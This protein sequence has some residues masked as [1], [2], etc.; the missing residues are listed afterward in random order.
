MRI[1]SITLLGLVLVVAP[2][3]SRAGDPVTLTRDGWTVT[4]DEA[5]AT[6]SIAH[7]RLGPL[8]ENARLGTEDDV[9]TPSWTSWSVAAGP[10]GELT[11][12]TG[13]SSTTW[14][15]APGPDTLIISST[16]TRAVLAGEAP[17]G[18]DRVVAR[19][20]DPSGVPVQW[21]GTNEVA[22]GYGGSETR[23]PSYLPTRNSDV[24]Y[25]GL[26]PVANG[27]F[28]A[29][30][31]RRSDTAVSFS[32][33]TRLKSHTGDP[34][35]IDLSIPVPGATVVRLV[36]DYYTT[37]LGVPFYERFDD[38]RFPRPPTI[39]CSWTSYYAEV[40]EEDMVKNA[41]WIAEHLLPWGFQ[42]VQ[43]DDGYD[44]GPHGEHYW[45]ERWDEKKFPHGPAWLAGYIKSKGLR[46]GLWLVPNAYAG[47]VETHPDWYLRD[48][49]GKLILDYNTPALDQTNPDVL[50]F[51]GQEFTTLR[52]WG[53]EYY[54]FDGEHALPLYVPA[55]DRSKLY[56]P[57]ADPIV[58]YRHRLSVIRDTVGPDT[59]I[60]GCPAGTPL[61]GIGY[62]DSYFDGHDVYNSWPGMFALFSSINANA[63]LNHMV[64]YLMPGEGIDVGPPMS[65][66]EAEKR[67]PPSF[68]RTARTRED[69]LTGF[70]T[71]LPE[72]R[73]LVTWLALTGVAYPVASVMP[74]LP[75][76]RVAL[77]QATLPP[78]PAL[79]IDLFSRGTDMQ[80]DRFKHV[81][82]D[83]YIHHYPEVLDLKV[84]GASGTYD[85][86]GI[87][88]WRAKPLHRRL[89]FHRTLGLEP[90][91]AVVAFDFWNQKPL[92]VFE[93]GLELD[94]EPHDTRVVL[95]HPLADR[96]QVIGTSRHITG[97]HSLLSLEWVAASRRL[98]GS[99][100]TVPGEEYTVF[101]QVPGRLL[102]ASAH[103]VTEGGREVPVQTVRDA[104]SV[105]LTFA[106]Q[107]EA[108]GWS[109]VFQEERP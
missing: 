58:A 28:H 16:S 53:F 20:L 109:I 96:P 49:E 27:P 100:R 107:P 36:P 31:D 39:W 68:V 76:E 54:K 7:E 12:Q 88:S 71:T 89:S 18:N 57:Q 62:F 43:L 55:V 90:G 34:G 106:G 56:D 80:W 48:R 30:F 50:A 46:P 61:N 70:G 1:L 45:I 4:A 44:R 51:L 24:M 93:D 98:D 63:F 99:S 75:L 82:P 103:A 14:T 79:P 105:R 29:L 15:L 26:G 13:P 86:V 8:V 6:L 42:Y 32:E 17:V 37:V 59:F 40:T 10:E 11:L 64:S 65:V 19:L 87:T 83:D 104:S 91:T 2:V 25:F 41:D 97:A 95:L 52:D 73:T 108:V 66:E 85:V 60:E 35:R 9:G 22:H 38:T 5:G 3:D 47:A 78:V 33:G 94:V 92:G 72:A 74:E 77:L 102:V 23:N 69:P 81:R 84:S 101:V 67:R 21:V